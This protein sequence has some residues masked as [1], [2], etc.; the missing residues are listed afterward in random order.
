MQKITASKPILT[1][2]F[3]LGY[4][5]YVALLFNVAFDK[6][7]NWYALGLVFLGFCCVRPEQITGLWQTLTSSATMKLFS[8]SM[9]GIVLIL[10]VATFRQLPQTEGL[11]S[12]G[13]QCWVPFA[14]ATLSCLILL[15]YKNGISYLLKVFTAGAITIA[16]FDIW[17]YYQQWA[18]ITP[19]DVGNRH[20][21]LADAYIFFIPFLF[22][23]AILNNS[24]L[25]K[26]TIWTLIILMSALS[27]GS[28]ARGIYI[29]LAIEWV[30]LL[31]VA[32]FPLFSDK[33]LIPFKK[34]L[35]P[36]S[37][38]I[39]VFFVTAHYIFPQFFFGAL[40]RGLSVDAR[41]LHTWQPTLYFIAQEPLS[42][43]GLGLN[44]WNS[45]YAANQIHLPGA[46]NVGSA[47]NWILQLGFQ[48]GVPLIGL[49]ALLV[50]S[51]YW[52][53]VKIFVYP[54]SDLLLKKSSF[55]IGLVF[56][57]FY[58]VRG[59]VETPNWK[60]F[61]LLVTF[62]LLLCCEYRMVLGADNKPR[63]IL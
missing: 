40:H 58:V 14:L 60:P 12:L 36:F 24:S 49:M 34:G 53:A 33:P 4:A 9:L 52:Q 30:I 57:G 27:I 29:V 19:M 51:Y 62:F 59:L 1:Q 10:S 32:V 43:F 18:A 46:I 21:E 61:Y 20:R 42:G 15:E 6:L 35:F 17:L 16:C 45:V 54:N 3:L 11:L 50:F 48:G 7:F 13:A 22:L 44:A 8:A 5:I 39:L 23:L 28:G 47:H 26:L 2:I 63:Q 31:R 25:Y 56:F 37:T 55:I 41:M 38:L